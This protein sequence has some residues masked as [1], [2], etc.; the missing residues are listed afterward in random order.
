MDEPVSLLSGS[1][2]T[3][4]P[5][6]V[7]VASAA[8]VPSD[9]AG[10]GEGTEVGRDG[11]EAVFRPPSPPSWRRRAPRLVWQRP[12]VRAADGGGERTGFTSRRVWRESDSTP[13][14][15]CRS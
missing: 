13:G 3:A 2:I 5:G 1:R 6:R 4:R 10:I 12:P 7:G 9:P 8:D 14:P 11:R 15:R